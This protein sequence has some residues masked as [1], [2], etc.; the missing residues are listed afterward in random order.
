MG[1][2]L[3]ERVQGDVPADADKLPEE[4]V[5]TVTMSMAEADPLAESSWI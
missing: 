4:I 1:L 2:C 5:E 3:S